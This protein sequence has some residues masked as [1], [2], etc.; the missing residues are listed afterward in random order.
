MDQATDGLRAFQMYNYTINDNGTLVKHGTAPTDYQTDVLTRRA[1]QFIDESETINDAQPFFLLVAPTAPHLE[2]P[3]PHPEW[4]YRF[5]LGRIY[6]PG[7][8]SYR[9]PA[10]WYSTATA[11][12]FQRSGCAG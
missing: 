10:R 8:P 3:R 9:H 11:S 6:P 7:S 5:G 1:R 4:L 2:G 12:E